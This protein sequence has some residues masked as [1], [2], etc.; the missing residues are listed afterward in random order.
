D[1]E[2]AHTVDIRAAFAF[3]KYEI[4]FEDYDKFVA[5]TGAT[6]PGDEGWGR[7]RQPAV[8]ISWND[9]LNY[10]RWLSAETGAVYR[11]PSEAEWEYAGRA[12]STSSYS[13]GGS[14][15]EG[16]ANCRGCTADDRNAAAPAG[17]FP[18][19][20]FG[21]HDLQGNVWEWV[22]D[23][24]RDSYLGAPSDGSVWQGE[25]ACSR[26]LRGGSWASSPYQLRSSYRNWYPA[27]DKENATGF[28]LVREIDP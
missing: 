10:A 14:V 4:T 20:A 2:P 16:M 24:A 27:D 28:R 15:G 21:L 5:A 26:V 9:A 25:D 12:G 8:N 23:C 19:N 13:W 17:S 11:L 22:D 3:G 18:V 1:E 7:G 6:P